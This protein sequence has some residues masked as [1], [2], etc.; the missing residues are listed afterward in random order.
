MEQQSMQSSP[1]RA[2]QATRNEFQREGRST[3]GML[4][5]KGA[6]EST[7]RTEQTESRPYLGNKK[8]IEGSKPDL[9]LKPGH[10]SRPSCAKM[11]RLGAGK[12]IL[13]RLAMATDQ[14]DS[15][16]KFNK[17][18]NPESGEGSNRPIIH[19]TIP[20][21]VQRASSAIEEEEADNMSE[22]DNHDWL[23]YELN[24]EEFKSAL[25]LR[26]KDEDSQALVESQPDHMPA[27]M[28]GTI[29]EVGESTVGKPILAIEK[30]ETLQ[31]PMKTEVEVEPSMNQ[32]IKCREK[33]TTQGTMPVN[34]VYVPLIGQKKDNHAAWKVIS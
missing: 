5:L 32:A 8:A 13:R 21:K 26:A 1:P 24:H 33:T 25:G 17:S 12:S 30:S 14:S 23:D 31:K 15:T 16:E 22:D 28:F 34:M 18:T 6:P 9:F 27:I 19:I 2:H 3:V 20:K 11:P 4:R 7:T 29:E 10:E